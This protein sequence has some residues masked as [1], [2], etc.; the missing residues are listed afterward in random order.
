MLDEIL[1][2]SEPPTEPI[3]VIW[4]AALAIELL[5]G[6][7]HAAAARLQNTL[8]DL[9]GTGAIRDAL[10][11]VSACLDTWEAFRLRRQRRPAGCRAMTTTDGY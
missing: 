2:D 5:G 6:A 7:L 10:R 11:T 4:P 1:R 9:K 3:E 8:D